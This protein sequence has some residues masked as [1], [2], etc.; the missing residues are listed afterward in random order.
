MLSKLIS[1]LEST[2]TS[3]MHAFKNLSA[4]KM[5]DD[6]IEGV[7]KQLLLADVGLETVDSI[8]DILRKF[9]GDNYSN[10]I[11]AYL[12]TQLPE[13]YLA[14]HDQLPIVF[15]MVGVNGTGKTTS[16][17]KLARAYRE[18]GKKVLLIAADTYRAAALDQLKIWSKRAD[19]RLVCNEKTKEP[20]AV[21]FDGLMVAKSSASEIIIVDT[22]G[23]L[24]TYDNLMHELEKMHR[25]ITNRFPEFLVKNLITID[26]LLGQ[27]SLVQAK[28]FN[29]HVPLDGAILTKLDGTAKG[30]IIFPLYNEL[31]IP[32]R[33]IGI[34]EDISDIE[35]FD[36]D[37]YLDGL[38]GKEL[39]K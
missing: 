32:V 34:G 13:K 31:N 39:D 4:D 2:R 36:P 9:S 37:N 20:S 1:A 35:L 7:E 18:K 8:I 17:A 10:K 24:H 3:I 27:N 19:V 25:I 16:A 14:I 15:M 12:L 30:G 11:R 22:A 38:L 5:S 23:R 33:Y 29:R 6:A 21:L 28:E 26:A